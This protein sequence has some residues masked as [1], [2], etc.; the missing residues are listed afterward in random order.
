MNDQGKHELREALANC[1]T[2]ATATI[3]LRNEAGEIVGSGWLER[4]GE[5]TYLARISGSSIAQ[6]LSASPPVTDG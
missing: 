6:I 3:I 5:D 1:P 4:T 2:W